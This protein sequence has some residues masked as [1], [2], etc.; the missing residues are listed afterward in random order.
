MVCFIRT[1]ADSNRSKR[2]RDLVA[3]SRAR[4][5]MY[6]LGNAQNLSARSKMWR[7]VIEELRKR[8]CLGDGFPV[9]CQRHP[10][11]VDFVKKP[12]QL[13]R[14]APDGNDTKALRLESY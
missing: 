5:G 9:A 7:E 4:E 3:L 8:E 2:V 14:I 11:T 13:P 12:G 1:E 10:Q 6:I